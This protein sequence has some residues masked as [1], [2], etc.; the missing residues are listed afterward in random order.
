M[1]QIVS[2]RALGVQWFDN[3]RDKLVKNTKENDKYAIQYFVDDYSRHNVDFVEVDVW[4]DGRDL[5]VGHDV[6]DWVFNYHDFYDC[7]S[8]IVHCKNLEAMWWLRARS[9][10]PSFDYFFHDQDDATITNQG[11][12]WVHPRMLDGASMRSIPTGSYVVVPMHPNEIDPVILDVLS[13]MGGVCTDF[14]EE[15]DKLLND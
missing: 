14:P 1:V 13:Q 15:M 11:K 4:G 7:S 6:G 5:R 3:T 9:V 12:I 10:P 2:H 8:L